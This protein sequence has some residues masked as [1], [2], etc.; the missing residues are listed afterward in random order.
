[1]PCR[2][3]IEKSLRDKI[4]DD[5]ARTSIG[6]RDSV[7]KSARKLDAKYSLK[8]AFRPHEYQTGVYRAAFVERFLPELIEKEYIK[9]YITENELDNEF[10]KQYGKIPTKE[11]TA[12]ENEIK[13]GV[14]ELFESNPELANTVYEAL[15]FDKKLAFVK[16]DNT[17]DDDF[18]IK[19]ELI[20]TKEL[21]NIRTNNFDG[22]INRELSELKDK[23]NKLPI[24]SKFNVSEYTKP[25][26][27]NLE[28]VLNKIN[29]SE[30]NKILL[31]KIRPLIK[32]IKIE[33]VDKFILADSGAVYSD[34]YNTIRINKSEKNIPLEELLMHE[35][36]HAATFRKISY[37]ET[38]TKGLSEKESLALNEL[39]NIRKVLKE[40]SDKYWNNRT[41]YARSVNPLEGYRTDSIHEIISYAFTNKEFRNAI[42][43]IPYTGNKSILDKLV[44]L[45]ANIFGV[46][47]NTVL[48]ALLANA[49]VLLNNNQIAP[50]QKQQAQ[51]KFQEYVN[52]TGKQ[53]VEGFKE[54]VN[55]E[56]PRPTEEEN[57]ADPVT[58]QLSFTDHS[59][60]N[61]VELTKDGKSI[62]QVESQLYTEKFDEYFPDYAYLTRKEKDFFIQ[63]FLDGNMP[64]NCKI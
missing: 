55:K 21:Q 25:S 4:A 20:I 54:F 32:D 34:K 42:A 17:I 52:T 57:I 36:L 38:N 18:Y 50:Q 62:D 33:Y 39:E 16:S 23:L 7:R 27:T 14:S 46:K 63:Q 12:A 59:F 41:R 49:E 40:A 13:P 53:D 28:E 22:S 60:Q 35:L 5:I 8:G 48:N 61:R 29:L 10:E 11:K 24:G 30:S 9:R 1:M 51:Q 6:T 15:G 2:T 43:E 45:I 31:E 56:Q 3:S 26:I 37:F 64:L 19:D 44:E 58:G 47:Q